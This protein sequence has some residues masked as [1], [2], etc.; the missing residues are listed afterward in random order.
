MYVRAVHGSILRVVSLTSHFDDFDPTSG[1]ALRIGWGPTAE[2]V[3]HV[4]ARSLRYKEYFRMDTLQ[5]AAVAAY[6]WPSALLGTF[7]STGAR[8]GSSP[9]SVDGSGE[10]AGVYLPLRVTQGAAGPNDEGAASGPYRMLVRPGRQLA[11]LYVSMWPVD[12]EGR[13]GEAVVEGRAL[14]YGYY[15]A[16]Q[17]I[18]AGRTAPGIARP[19]PAEPGCR[20]S[21]RR[22]GDDRPLALPRRSGP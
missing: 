21:G 22:F 3:V 19:L 6:S 18:F 13:R 9:G 2:G 15:P 4:R 14:E 7:G 11:E 8:S 10:G 1:E 5:P 16:D 17:A 20:R 12:G